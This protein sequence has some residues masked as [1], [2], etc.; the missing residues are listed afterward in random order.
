MPT[1]LYVERIGKLNML[2]FLPAWL[3]GVIAWFLYWLNSFFWFIPL[4]TFAVVKIIPIDWVRKRVS[5]ILDFSAASWVSINSLIQNLTVKTQWDVEGLEQLDRKEWYMVLANHQ[6]WVDI[7][8]VQRVLSGKVPFVKFFLK[9]ELIWVPFFG[10]AWWA[11]DYPFMVRYNKKFLRKNPHLK[12]KDV[13][14]TKKACEK[15]RYKPVCVL[16]FAEGTRFTDEKHQRQ[17]GQYQ[18]LLKPKAG[19]TAFVLGTMGDSLHKIIDITIFYPDGIPTFWQFLC[20]QVRKV[21][22]R[23]NVEDITPELIGDYDNDMDYRKS[24]QKYMNERWL[25]KDLLMQTLS[26]REN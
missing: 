24:M 15:F 11:L 4:F 25:Q 12:G 21:V 6:S 7:M 19:G 5:Y 2:A 22:V 23:V 26:S 9:R 8:V 1:V 20:G 16:N 17:Q 3:I 14:T 13:E 10:L 18:H